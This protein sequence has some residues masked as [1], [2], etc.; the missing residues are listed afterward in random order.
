MHNG[1]V[2]S[3][4]GFLVDVHIIDDDRSTLLIYA[5]IAQSC[6][7]SCSTFSNPMAYLETINQPDYQPPHVILTDVEMPGL[8]GYEL[9]DSIRASYP[10]QRFIVT[11]SSPASQGC[12][13][14][15]CL[16]YQKPVSKKDLEAAFSTLLKC[17]KSGEYA[18]CSGKNACAADDRSQFAIKQ[19]VCP[20]TVAGD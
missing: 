15:A 18:Q 20:F 17:I 1:I 9:I 4:L 19:W 8:S 2:F 12:S 11:T 16:Y 14:S 5:K 7:L 10:Q 6:G 13:Q 3:Q